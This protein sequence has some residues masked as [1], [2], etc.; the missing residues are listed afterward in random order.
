[1]DGQE[2]IQ[3]VFGPLAHD[4]H[5]IKTM[6]KAI[7]GT[8]PWLKDPLCAKRKWDESEYQLSEHGGG[9]SLCFGMMYDDGTVLPQPP[10]VRGMEITK[11]ALEAAGHRGLLMM[12]SDYLGIM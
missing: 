3:C 2:S 12:F 4:L 11:A 10:I 5:G 6:V 7:A 8:K 1:M 9:Q